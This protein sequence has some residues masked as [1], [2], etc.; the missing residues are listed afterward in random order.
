MSEKAP[1]PV[2]HKTPAPVKQT[3]EINH[4]GKGNGDKAVVIPEMAI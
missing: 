1:V 4:D 2:E 3:E